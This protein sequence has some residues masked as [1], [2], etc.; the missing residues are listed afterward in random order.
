[1]VRMRKKIL[2]RLMSIFISKKIEDEYYSADY[3]LLMSIRNKQ[4]LKV[5]H[6]DIDRHGVSY[7]NM[8]SVGAIEKNEARRIRI[9][10]RVRKKNNYMNYPFYSSKA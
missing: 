7:E 6:I 10:R 1:M 5:C 2:A 8:F 4:S 9:Y 3:I